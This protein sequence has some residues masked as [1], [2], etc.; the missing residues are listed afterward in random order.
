MRKA[1]LE[2]GFDTHSRL[3]KKM[4]MSRPA[5]SRAESANQ[6][7]PSEALLAAWARACGVPV[8]EFTEIVQRAKSGQPE[9]FVPYVGAERLATSVRIWQP[10]LVPGLCQT[11]SYANAI[12]KSEAVVTQRMERQQ[13]LGRTRVIAVI[14]YGVLQRCI[15]SAEIMSRQCA[16]LGELVE[17]EKI[18][19]HVV[20]EGTNTGLGGAVALA[21]H[22]G[23]TTVSLTT[24][25][26]EITSTASDV[27][28]D[29]VFGFDEVLGAALGAVPSL[30]F[31][32]QMEE[33]WKDRT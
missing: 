2:A 26:R 19:L 11:E 31:V 16:H 15:G 6:P 14:E 27:V 1:R 10:S 5:I 30:A 8:E 21:A 23:I 18:R 7:V 17:S 3:A 24:M 22:N 32:R 20:P 9:W 13:I 12:E 28:E 29:A 33:T 25:I 4:N